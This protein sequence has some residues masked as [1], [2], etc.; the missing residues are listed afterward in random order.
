MCGVCGVCGVCGIMYVWGVW[1]N[2]CVGVT[3][4]PLICC[5]FNVHAIT[6]II[7]VDKSF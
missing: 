7:T 1:D 2:V 5:T 4:L 3:E 6:I